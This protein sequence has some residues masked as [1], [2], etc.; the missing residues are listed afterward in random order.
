MVLV[1][2]PF[3]DLSTQK[4][5]PALVVSPS[6]FHAEDLIL[7]AITSQVPRRLSRWEIELQAQDLTGQV[8]PKPSVIRI[9]KLITL[10]R[11]LIVG[12]FG[13]VREEK[14]ADVLARLRVLF[15]PADGRMGM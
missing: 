10:H 4:R 15:G 3:T 2:F 13:V 12:Q 5:R 11:E 8:L 9:G 14:L 6:G 7:C 1:P